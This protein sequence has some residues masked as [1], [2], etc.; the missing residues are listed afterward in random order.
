MNTH[1]LKIPSMDFQLTAA[2]QCFCKA[3]KLH[4]EQG[5]EQLAAG[6]YL[7]LA[8][9][10]RSMKRPLEALHYYQ[11]AVT[12]SREHPVE[13]IQA[14]LKVASCYITTKDHHNALLVLSD[15][16]NIAKEHDHGQLNIYQDVQGNVEILRVLL[17]LIIEPS[18]HNTSPHML[19]V[20]DKYRVTE[21]TLDFESKVSPYLSDEVCIL[22]QSLVIAVDSLQV[23]SVLY[24]EDQLEP[25][26]TD[27]Q[28]SLLRILVKQTQRKV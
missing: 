1:Y 20:L 24:C 18:S 5:R 11:K 26:L 21:D 8:E 25:L 14:K 19:S 9:A 3:A 16:V 10:Y 23:D 2:D 13:I 12:L 6:L 22:L 28:N 15:I 27:E 17:L 4:E 7:E